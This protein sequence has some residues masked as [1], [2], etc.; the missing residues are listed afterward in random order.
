MRFGTG[1]IS[2]TCSGLIS[3]GKIEMIL[4]INGVV[5]H[6]TCMYYVSNAI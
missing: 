2:H 5:F 3:F 4:L 6:C 1:P